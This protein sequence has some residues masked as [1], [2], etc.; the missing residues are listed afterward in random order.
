MSR[1]TQ[2]R[3]EFLTSTTKTLFVASLLLTGLVSSSARAQHE[4]GGD[5][6]AAGAQADSPALD[7][8]EEADDQ[9]K[10]SG[11]DRISRIASRFRGSVF[12]F[13]QSITPE[14]MSAGA[15]LSQV[16][17]YQWWLSLRPRFYIKPNL[18]LRVRMDLTVEWLNGG[19]DTTYRRQPIFGDI[20]TDIAYTPK[21]FWGIQ[22][23]VTGRFIF[24]SSLDSQANS[25]VMKVG[26]AINFTRPFRTKIGEF[27]P[28]LGGYALY[29]FVTNTSA[30]VRG[31][32]YSCTSTDY[33]PTV[34]SQSTG[35]MNSQAQLVV[36]LGA[37][38][39]PHPKV[40]IN[41]NYIIL[42]S[43]AYNTPDATIGGPSSNGSGVPRSNN[44]T[45]FRQSSWFLA[46][47]DYDATSYL[48]LSLGYYVLRKVRDADGSIGD[49]F[50]HGDGDT[51]VFLTTVFNLDK[52]YEAIARRG[53]RNKAASAS[54]AKAT[55]SSNALVTF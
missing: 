26:P 2:Q 53:Q 6:G 32:G 9:I 5:R 7:H 43:W 25:T 49:P 19:A 1:S 22:T 16:P 51:R 42:D 47:V 13:D 44:D 34:C 46:S 50:Y 52:V 27:E 40:G 8:T 41:L 54:A 31:D 11:G 21:P 39:S 18:S 35:K 24:P 36:I 29:N 4:A 30:G 33:T 17:S 20:W 45:R 3:S 38:Y 15:Q 23:T 14:T 55:A 48:S 10:K 37:R 12:L 28:S